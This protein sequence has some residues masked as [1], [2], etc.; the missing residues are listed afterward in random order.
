MALGIYYTHGAWLPR[1]LDSVQC[2]FGDLLDSS[3]GKS[4]W[5]GKKEVILGLSYRRG[6]GRLHKIAEVELTVE[7]QVRDV[8]IHHLSTRR[9]I[10]LH[11]DRRIDSSLCSRSRQGN[12]A[13]LAA[14]SAAGSNGRRVGNDTTWN[15]VSEVKSAIEW[16][17]RGRYRG[18]G[19][20]RGS[21]GRGS[22]NRCYGW[23][24][25]DRRRG[26]GKLLERGRRSLD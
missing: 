18:Q 6:G 2:A 1:K 22:G 17:R 5:L 24:L 12:R 15:S 19:C 23:K 7:C 11:R 21:P 8:N 20:E 3:R 10:W 9:N 26:A 25:V 13:N 14:K 16:G 4:T